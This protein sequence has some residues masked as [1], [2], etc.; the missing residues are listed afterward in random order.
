MLNIFHTGGL[1]LGLSI[2]FLGLASWLF[3]QAYK[4]HN[5]GSYTN[6]EYGVHNSDEKIPYV[7][8]PQFIGGLLVLIV[9]II[10]LF[11]VASDY[12]GV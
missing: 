11:L 4:A 7:Q 8:I 3:Y 12:K 1:T 5:S 10:C 6:D 9:Y 2:V